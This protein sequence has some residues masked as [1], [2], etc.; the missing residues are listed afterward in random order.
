MQLFQAHDRCAALS[1]N[2]GCLDDSSRNPAKTAC[3]LRKSCEHLC[4]GSMQAGFKRILGTSAIRIPL[5]VS[6]T[7]LCALVIDAIDWISNRVIRT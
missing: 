3:S 2:R 6:E 7:C 5:G 4:S 1:A